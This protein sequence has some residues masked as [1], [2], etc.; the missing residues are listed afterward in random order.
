MTEKDC[1]STGLQ[2]LYKHMGK[3]MTSAKT[4]QVCMLAYSYFTILTRQSLSQRVWMMDMY[5]HI[6][7]RYY[8]HLSANKPQDLPA[9]LDGFGVMY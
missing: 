5:K 8:S 2:S 3:W 4:N 7:L 9:V 6:L 1:T